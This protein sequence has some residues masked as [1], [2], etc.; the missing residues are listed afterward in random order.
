MCIYVHIQIY[1]LDQ[2]VQNYANFNIVLTTQMDS[3]LASGVI[4]Y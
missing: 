1:K 2:V 4:L 3:N